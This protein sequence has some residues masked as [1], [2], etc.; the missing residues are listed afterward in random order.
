M[1]F[2]PRLDATSR[3]VLQYL[4]CKGIRKDIATFI[5]NCTTCKRNKY[6]TSA[7]LGLLQPLPIPALPW[8]EITMDFIEGLPKSKSKI[9]I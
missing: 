6:D 1:A 8:N 4:Y 9:V 3:K 2:Y 5:Q 7:S